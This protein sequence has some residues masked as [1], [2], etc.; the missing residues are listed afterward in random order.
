[1]AKNNMS[2]QDVADLKRRRENLRGRGRLIVGYASTFDTPYWADCSYAAPDLRGFEIIRRGAFLK[3]LARHDPVNLTLNHSSNLVLGELDQS[4]LGLRED[5]IGLRFS[6][7]FPHSEL[8]DEILESIRRGISGMS[9]M[10]RPIR[11]EPYSPKNSFESKALAG[12]PAF[13]VLEARVLDITFCN[14]GANPYA[15]VCPPSQEQ[16]YLS[17]ISEAVKEFRSGSINW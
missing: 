13:E 8:H 10:L 6:F 16:R 4:S 11:I 2:L 15:F 14:K 1:M 5:D 3:T 12:K 9:F 7:Y 17:R